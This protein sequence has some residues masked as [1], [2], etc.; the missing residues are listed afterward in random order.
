MSLTTKLIAAGL[1]LL[2]LLAGWNR[3]TAYHERIGY[4]RRAA[5]DKAAADAQTERNRELQRAA[6]RRYTVVVQQHVTY[7]TRAAKE[8][9]DAAAPLSA[10]PVPD[11]LRR[12][13]NDAASC[14]RGD[15]SAACGGDGTVRTP[16]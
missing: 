2:A 9:N 14:A 8:I 12:L 10:C 1:I 3:L 4:D 6:E 13:L 5:E 7:F 16:R 11:D 15:P